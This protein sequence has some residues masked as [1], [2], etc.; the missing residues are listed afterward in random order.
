MKIADC[1]I[2]FNEKRML[3]ERVRLLYD[4]VD[5]FVIVEAHETFTQQPKPSY[6]NEAVRELQ[7]P[8]DKL[9]VVRLREWASTGNEWSRENEQRENMLVGLRSL[10]LSPTDLVLISDV[11]EIPSLPLTQPAVD[12]AMAGGCS[13]SQDFFYYCFKWR[14]QAKWNGTVLTTFGAVDRVGPQWFRDRRDAL[15]RV[16]DGGFHLSFWGS[17]QD[18]ITKLQNYPHQEHNVDSVVNA[19]HIAA[20]VALGQDL[21]GRGGGDALVAQAEVPAP[22]R[23]SGDAWFSRLSPSSVIPG[24]QTQEK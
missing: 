21:F 1:F 18:V 24:N 20:S 10:D 12:L 7:I 15:P 3:A 6:L 14:K 13:M 23:D 9:V 19:A 5:Y 11:D 8:T 2:F 4:H 16:P 17:V 22:F